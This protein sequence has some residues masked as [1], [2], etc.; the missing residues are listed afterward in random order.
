MLLIL[1]RRSICFPF[2]LKRCCVD[3]FD[4]Q[5]CLCQ[6]VLY[7]PTRDRAAGQGHH[8]DKVCVLRSREVRQQVFTINEPT[9]SRVT[10]LNWDP[11]V[12]RND[13]VTKKP[14]GEHLPSRQ[15]KIIWDVFS[16][17]NA[18]GEHRWKV[19][20]VL[21][22]RRKRELERGGPVKRCRCYE[23]HLKS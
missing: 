1:D 17:Q 3:S 6:H 19:Y 9:T 5:I 13:E 4:M 8:D 23:G 20:V 11:V 10:L 21:F 14:L 22:E 18:F 7:W 2:F 15:S 12:D 16:G